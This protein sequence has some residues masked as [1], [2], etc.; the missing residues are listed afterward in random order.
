MVISIAGI[1]GQR[2]ADDG[3]VLLP[4]IARGTPTGLPT[5]YAP[6]LFSRPKLATP[7]ARRDVLTFH[8]LF[9][10]RRA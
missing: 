1:H 7:S 4:M 6:I 9:L 5:D 2:R 8:W 10:P 3:V